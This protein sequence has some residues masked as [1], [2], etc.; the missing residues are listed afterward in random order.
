MLGF[1]YNERAVEAARS[2]I[3]LVPDARR[4][5]FMAEK[6]R[7]DYVFH[8]AALEGNPFTFPEVKTLIEGIT[9]G[10]RKV[11]DAAQVM[12]LNHALNDLLDAVREHRFMLTAETACRLQGLVAHE[13]ALTWGQ[14]RDGVVF[15]QGTDYLP[16]PA[17]ELAEIFAAGLADLMRIKD[18]VMQALLLFLWGSLR[19]FFYDG[20]KR[21]SRL[22][23]NGVLLSA[24]Y[25]P[26]LILATD[27]LAYNQTMTA[28]YDTQEATAALQWLLGYYAKALPRFGFANTD[29]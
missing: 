14:F 4:A 18:P 29:Q 27:Q 8:A 17:G 13:E 1:T 24:G 10:G 22:L 23:A 7:V 3:K 26:L 19:Q 15:I 16:P 28:F 12:N 21:T 6:S 5:L 20:N 2:T 9:V 25:P 11:S